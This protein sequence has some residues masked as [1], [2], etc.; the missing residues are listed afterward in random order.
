MQ[1]RRFLI[2][3]LFFFTGFFILGEL[4]FGIAIGIS[5]YF[6]IQI[7]VESSRVF[8]F[9]EWALFLYAVNYLFSPAVTYQLDKALLTYP[10]RIPAADYFAIAIPGFLCLYGDVFF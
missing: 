6:L 10:M 3:G 9:R 2:F 1:L 5:G 8:A 4:Y 7:I